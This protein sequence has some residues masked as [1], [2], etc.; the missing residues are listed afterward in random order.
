[1]ERWLETSPNLS[2]GKGADPYLGRKLRRCEDGV[3]SCPGFSVTAVK[4]N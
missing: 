2:P 1:M 3:I 4:E